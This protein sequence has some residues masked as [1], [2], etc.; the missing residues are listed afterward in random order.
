M[1]ML[2]DPRPEQ[3]ELRKVKA[4]IDPDWYTEPHVRRFVRWA[5]AAP[6][7]RSPETNEG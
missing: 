7:P 6:A 3:R 1:E 2:T 5:A 4:V